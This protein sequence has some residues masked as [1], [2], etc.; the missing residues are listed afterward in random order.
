[1]KY[2]LTP[3][4]INLWNDCLRC[5]WLTYN[6]KW[7]RPSAPFP[8][9]PSGI[10]K[11]L[12]E[13]FD[14]YR[15]ND[16]LPPEIGIC[17]DMEDYELFG[18]DENGFK[19]LNKWRNNFLGL[20]YV[21]EE[22]NVLKGAIDDLLVKD[23]NVYVLDFKTR[24]FPLKEDTF[25]HYVSQLELY[26]FLLKNNGF[27]TKKSAFLLF[28]FPER[29]YALGEIDFETQLLEI[30]LKNEGKLIFEEAIRFLKGH[31]PDKC[32]EWCRNMKQ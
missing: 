30:P 22:G 23:G 26:T 21:D 8:S 7:K 25:K 31:C 11:V 15:K 27:R 13:H 24:G 10:D 16:A 3:S 28:Y 14:E 9:L 6:K 5:F 20:S 12:K 18:T 4:G 32:C 2:K 1:M 17:R 19:L 29:A